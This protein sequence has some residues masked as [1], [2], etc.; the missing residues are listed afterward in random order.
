RP[1][2]HRREPA[3]GRPLAGHRPPDPTHEA[4]GPGTARRAL[5]RSRRRAVGVPSLSH[6]SATAAVVIRAPIGA[7]PD[8][9]PPGLPRPVAGA[10][11]TSWLP[12]VKLSQQTASSAPRLPGVVQDIHQPPLRELGDDL[13]LL[14][15]DDLRRFSRELGREVHEIAPEAL[16]RL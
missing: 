4:P 7:I 10:L 14:V 2:V 1:G 15:H 6:A 3:P 8:Q 11:P 5:R 13:P 16:E 12:Y 9:A